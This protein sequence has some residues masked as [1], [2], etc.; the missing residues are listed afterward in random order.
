MVVY[1]EKL[2]DIDLK[3]LQSKTVFISSH[4]LQTGGSEEISTR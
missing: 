4:Q 2:L 3:L 1:A